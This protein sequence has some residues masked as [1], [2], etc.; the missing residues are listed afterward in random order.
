MMTRCRTQ[1]LILLGAK[2]PDTRD[3]VAVTVFDAI[4]Q[5]R[6]QFKKAYGYEW[7]NPVITNLGIEIVR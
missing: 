3:V 5:L 4:S 6:D 7:Y 1:A 2:V